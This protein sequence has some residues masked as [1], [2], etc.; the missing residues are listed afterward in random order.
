MR[1]PLTR[2][3]PLT[4][5]N[6]WGTTLDLV[7]RPSH[8]CAT[9]PVPVAS[10]DDVLSWLCLCECFAGGFSSPLM[11]AGR[12]TGTLFRVHLALLP[13]MPGEGVLA[14]AFTSPAASEPAGPPALCRALADIVAADGVTAPRWHGA[15]LRLRTRL[16]TTDALPRRSPWHRSPYDA[17]LAD[18]LAWAARNPPDP[19]SYRPPLAALARELPEYHPAAE[20]GR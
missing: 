13:G 6:R 20:G 3:T 15:A 7:R 10:P 18:P 14:L 17:Q 1:D 4:R 8:F 9:A 11:V 19:G 16:A 2:A 5:M 12:L